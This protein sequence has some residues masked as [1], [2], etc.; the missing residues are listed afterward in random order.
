M[1]E[2]ES[3]N[4]KLNISTDLLKWFVEE[5]PGF[6][7][8][9]NENGEIISFSENSLILFSIDAN[10]EEKKYLIENYIGEENWN[11]LKNNIF[12]INENLENLILPKPIGYLNEPSVNWKMFQAENEKI[13]FII[14]KKTKSRENEKSGLEEKSHQAEEKSRAFYKISFDLLNSPACCH[15]RQ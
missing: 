10:T 12:S 8:V 15:C 1:N 5:N 11:L 7:L 14:F 2:E 3:V 9:I 6:Y 13:Y 4:I